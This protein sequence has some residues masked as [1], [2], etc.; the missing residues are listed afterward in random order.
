VN[1]V[2]AGQAF[3]RRVSA[4]TDI[5][6]IDTYIYSLGIYNNAVHQ[7]INYP[8]MRREL[9]IGGLTALIEAHSP[10]DFVGSYTPVPLRMLRAANYR[11]DQWTLP[12]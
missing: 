1:Q 8:I 10:Q 2:G 7:A 4:A 12:E 9:L 5:E 11:L 3:Q 6:L